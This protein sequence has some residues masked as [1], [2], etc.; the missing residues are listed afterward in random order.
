M[1]GGDFW[2]DAAVGATVGALNHMGG[3]LLGDKNKKVEDKELL[4]KDGKK[5]VD[6]AGVGVSSA[7]GVAKSL[8]RGELD[9]A[10]GRALKGFLKVAGRI[11]GGASL[12]NDGYSIYKKGIFNATKSD[13]LKLGVSAFTVFAKSNPYTL[14]FSIV[15]GVADMAG[16]NP[17]NYIP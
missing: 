5:I 16:Y 12:A 10:G 14:S 2:R 15:Y 11:T 3:K 1:S 4:S 6:G 9:P 13:Y 7:E 17:L 8:A